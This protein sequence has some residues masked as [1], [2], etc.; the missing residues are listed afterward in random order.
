MGRSLNICAITISGLGKNLIFGQ[1]YLGK[2]HQYRELRAEGYSRQHLSP[3]SDLQVHLTISFVPLLCFVDSPYVPGIET[4]LPWRPGGGVSP[5]TVA[6][7]SPGVWRRPSL[8]SAARIETALLWRRGGG[9][10]PRTAV[11]A[12]PRFRRRRS[13]TSAAG[14]Q[15]ALLGDAAAAAASPSDGVGNDRGFRTSWSDFD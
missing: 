3:P 8:T 15:T 13:R 1:D 5:R 9:V 14:I 7:V 10:S 12:C 2:S 6:T 4:A 11:T